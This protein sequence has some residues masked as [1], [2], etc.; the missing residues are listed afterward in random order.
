VSAN[1]QAEEQNSSGTL[2]LT[3]FSAGQHWHSACGPHGDSSVVF[4]AFTGSTAA[5]SQP[6]TPHQSPA[7]A[8]PL[9]HPLPPAPFPPLPQLYLAGRG[10]Q[11]VLDV[12]SSLDNLQGRH[13]LV[14]V[15]C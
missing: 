12:Y 13:S 9:T 4:Q 11:R 8:V 5:W 10:L 6:W 3:S 2:G 15:P 14:R 1:S 7:A